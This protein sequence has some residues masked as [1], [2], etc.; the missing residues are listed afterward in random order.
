VQRVEL[1]VDRGGRASE[2][3]DFVNLDIVGKTHVVAD[4]FEAQLR[5]QMAH[6]V[7]RACVE[8]VNAEDFMASLKQALAYGP[9]VTSTRISVNMVAIPLFRLPSATMIV[10]QYCVS[11]GG[12]SHRY[13]RNYPTHF[14]C[15]ASWSDFSG[16]GQ[17]SDLRSDGRTFVRHDICHPERHQQTPHRPDRKA[18]PQ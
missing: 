16:A 10:R 15:S 13:E 12:L 17:R 3:V 8:I 5:E 7:A 11:G 1:I 18:L 4:Q 9:P 6:V 14:R 2:I